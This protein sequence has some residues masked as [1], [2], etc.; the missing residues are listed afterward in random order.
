MG[1]F[2][3]LKASSVAVNAMGR[4]IRRVEDKDGDTWT[5]TMADVMFEQGSNGKSLG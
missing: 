5:V 2:I 1:V 3:E 4:H